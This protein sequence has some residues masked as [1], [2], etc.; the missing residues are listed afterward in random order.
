M[1]S[2]QAAALGRLPARR[3]GGRPLGAYLP[4]IAPGR[5]AGLRGL[6]PDLGHDGHGGLRRLTPS[7][8]AHGALRH[9]IPVI[10][11][12]RQMHALPYWADARR[13]KPST[14]S[15]RL[16]PTPASANSKCHL[17]R[18][19]CDTMMGGSLCALGAW[20]SHRAVRAEP[21]SA[22][23]FGIELF[24]AARTRPGT[25]RGDHAGT[26]IKRERDLAH[27]PA[28]ENTATL[29]IDGQKSACPKRTSLMRA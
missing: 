13:R 26:V 6:Y 7:T 10:E 28:S 27:R 21:L 16:G 3:A 23:D 15:R 19:L 4:G 1:N 2:A 22:Q 20:R 8:C 25:P 5:A 11:F 17:L 29:T 14:R 9:G 24:A 12:L 18:D